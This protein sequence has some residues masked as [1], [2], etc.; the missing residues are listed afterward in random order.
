MVLIVLFGIYF[1]EISVDDSKTHRAIRV[2][3]EGYDAS[4]LPSI[5]I[6]L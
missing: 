5:R 4:N 3:V 1:V 2:C 6:G